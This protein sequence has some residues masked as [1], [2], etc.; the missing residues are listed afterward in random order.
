MFSRPGVLLLTALSLSLAPAYGQQQYAIET[1]AGLDFYNEGGSPLDS[2][3]YDVAG[4]TVRPDGAVC[5]SDASH[6]RIRCFLNDI[7]TT[8]AGSGVSGSSGDGGPALEARFISPVGIAAGPDGSL[9]IADEAA[10]V[11]RRVAPDGT[12]AIFA[13]T[14]EEGTEGED[15]PAAEAQLVDP[16]DVAVDAAGNVYITDSFADRVVVVGA[17]GML[18]RFAGTGRFGYSGDGGQAAL[19]RLFDPSAL[20][21]GPNGAVYIADSTNEVI[22]RVD[23]D[24]IIRTV[25]GTGQAGFFGD[26]GAPLQ[27]RLDNPSALAVDENGVLYIGDDNNRVRSV[28]FTTGII[29][30]IAGTGDPNFD[31]EGPS[32]ERSLEPV[33]L[34]AAPG[35]GV[36]VAAGLDNHLLLVRDGETTIVAGRSHF[37]GDG[38]L[39]TEASLGLVAGIESGSLLLADSGNNRVRLINDSGFIDTVAGDG[40]GDSIGDGGP[41]LEAGVPPADMLREPDGSL[42]ILDANGFLRRVR[43]DG[44]I[45]RV[46]GDG[47]LRLGNPAEGVPASQ[48]SLGIPHDLDRDSEGNIY[49]LQTIFNDTFFGPLPE[50]IVRRINPAGRIQTVLG[51]GDSANENVLALQAA[52]PISFSFAV[53]PNGRICYAD[54]LRFRLR[55]LDPDGIVRTVSGP[56]GASPLTPEG[57]QQIVPVIAAG[58]DIDSEGTIF[59]S[60]TAT[61]R[62]R[63]IGADGASVSI[64]GTGDA[65]FSGDGGPAL[66]A[67]L[68]N[69]DQLLVD[70]EGRISFFDSQ[71][72]RIRRLT[73]SAPAVLVSAVANAASFTSG[74]TAAEAIVSLF[75]AQ[76][77]AVTEVATEL[78][79]PTM[80]SGVTVDVVDNAGETRAA[81]LFFISAGQINLEI[82]AGTAPGPAMLRVTSP[83]GVGELAIA[84]ETVAP[85]L[86]AINATGE[87]VAAAAAIRVAADGAQTVAQVFDASQT[88][89]AA[90]PI[91]LGPEGEQ[92]V[93]LLFGTGIRG[94]STVEVAMNGEAAQVLGFAAQPDFV[95]LDQIN[96]IIPRSLIGAGEVTIVVTVDGKVA[97]EVTISVM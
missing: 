25:V 7:F 12:I 27:A 56:A 19:A 82:P 44:T 66:A 40:S 65:G 24:G 10:A 75:G 49:I 90:A 71:N 38:G 18:R 37:S 48:S 45:Q 8:V 74:P 32:T 34:A 3:L 4:V 47:Q 85:G 80:L 92:V 88:P 91:D 72:W 11:V 53:G 17:D 26:G 70:S 94:A 58:I 95:G 51:G 50:S 52:I 31:G 57:M 55:C 20:A 6:Y 60:D 9:Y 84:I 83:A 1:I 5:V 21:I 76:L 96:A 86:F 79:L 59:F 39:A 77:A 69:P 41:A 14:G 73:P 89:I 22:R 33:G 67:K 64:A 97:N 30:T 23:A 28:N 63:L 93:L 2:R 29:T 16:T 36:Y 35:G 15:G 62:I 81:R 42:L 68:H 46:A 61:D 13:G 54:S 43:P 78:P 87:G